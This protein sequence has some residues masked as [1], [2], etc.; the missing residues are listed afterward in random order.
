MEK[1]NCPRLFSIRIWRH[2]LNCFIK[3][4]WRTIIQICEINPTIPKITNLRMDCN[5]YEA[6]KFQVLLQIPS[7]SL[8][9]VLASYMVYVY[10]EFLD[11]RSSSSKWLKKILKLYLLWVVLWPLE[12]AYFS[13]HKSSQITVRNAL[14]FAIS[15]NLM[16]AT[17][18][19]TEFCSFCKIFK[20]RGELVCGA[21]IS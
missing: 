10:S 3:N 4:Q 21:Q 8:P 20:W 18:R 15:D 11:R 7:F 16:Y 1:S 6:R 14:L 2:L 12:F 13:L 19:T 5:L 9:R 17:S